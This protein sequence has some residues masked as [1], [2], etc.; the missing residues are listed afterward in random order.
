VADNASTY[1]RQRHHHWFG[2][3]TTRQI[4]A[5]LDTGQTRTVDRKHKTQQATRDN[6]ELG[7]VNS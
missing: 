1:T 3:A 7:R 2:R 4:R 5:T 6:L